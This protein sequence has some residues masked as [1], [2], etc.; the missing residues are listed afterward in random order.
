LIVEHGKLL[1]EH[2]AIIDMDGTL[3]KEIRSG[4]QGADPW[5]NI[6]QHVPTP[7]NRLSYIYVSDA[8]KPAKMSE[9]LEGTLYQERPGFR[10]RHASR[11]FVGV[12]PRVGWVY[13]SALAQLM[14][15]RRHYN[16]ITDNETAHRVSG[17]AS[18]DEFASGLLRIDRG[19]PRASDP[20]T[21]Y[22]HVAIDDVIPANLGG[23]SIDRLIRFRD[24]RSDELSAFH[25]HVEGLRPLLAT[26]ADVSDE[27]ALLEHVRV[28]YQ[29]ETRPLISNLRRALTSDGFDTV[30]T[31]LTVKIDATALAGTALGT[32]S[33][34]TGASPIMTAAGVAAAVVP[35]VVSAYR[36]RRRKRTESP[37]AYLIS[38]R[39][40]LG[41]ARL[42]QRVLGG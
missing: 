10:L 31:A 29:R 33:V 41:S 28:I 30:G 11:C 24:R 3:S 42:L 18:V 5:S 8:G 38:A 35:T 12:H 23:I 1:R 16:T 34:A 39:A 13:M 7:S 9:S 6:L 19:E 25:K 22:L 26:V 4:G 27:R 20:T 32:A 15:S 36:E 21:M 2:Y 14:A 37:V 40:E 17:D